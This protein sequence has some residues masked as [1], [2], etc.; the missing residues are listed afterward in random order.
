MQQI[1]SIVVKRRD[2]R[3]NSMQDF[4]VAKGKRKDGFTL[5]EMMIVVGIIGVLLAIAIPSFQ[6]AR[7]ESRI[8]RAKSELQLITAAVRQLTWDTGKW[9]NTAA[10]GAPGSTEVWGLTPSSAGLVAATATY[11]TG[12]RGPYVRTISKDP[13]GKNYFFDPD[14][15][16]SGVNR[17]VV[18][19]FGP[20]GVGQNLYDSDDIYVI[21][22]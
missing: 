16:I 11:G 19:S 2:K 22:R 15:L 9:P 10:Y 8:K 13:W 14:Y 20:N 18:G 1:V 17:I 12:W 5:L 3:C 6:K 4:R 7:T 21:L